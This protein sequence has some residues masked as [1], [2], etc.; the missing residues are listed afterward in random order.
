MNQFRIRVIFVC[1]VLGL[2]GTAVVTR[3]FVVQIIDGKKYAL[4]SK[5]QA[6]QRRI[7]NAKRGCIRDRKGVILASSIPGKLA[8]STQVL[9][10]EGEKGKKAILQRI[11]PAGDVC[12]P[13]LGYIGSDGY[14]LGGAEFA[15]D[16]YLRG[17]DGWEM[18]QK[19][20]R[21]R[22]YKKIGLPQKE[23]LDGSDVYLT[24][25]SDLQK[26]VQ[27][28]LK[29]TV[30]S[31]QARGAMCI[32]MD[33][34]NGKILA[35]ANEPSFNPNVSYMYSLDERRNRCISTV[36]EPGSTFKVVTASVA[37]QEKLFKEQD[38]IDGNNGIFE[39]YNQVIRDVSPQKIITF[40]QAMAVSSNVCFAQ[41]AN[42]FSN[43]LFYRYAR[44]FGFGSKTGIE[45]PGEEEGIL[46][47]V[48]AWSGRTRVT[49]AMGHEV[50][51]TFL[52][53]MLPF[54]CVANGGVLVTPTI[55]EKVVNKNGVVIQKS[56]SK[57]VRKVISGD[58]V[59]KL[60]RM[61]KEVVDN[62][63]GKHAIISGVAVAGKT[64]T[65]R[66][67][68][69]GGY[70]RNKHWSSFIGFLPADDPVLLCGIV[71]DEPVGETGGGTVAAPAFQKI[72]SQVLSHPQ[73]EFAEKILDKPAYVVSKDSSE[74]RSSVSVF[75]KDS[76]L[77]PDSAHPFIP[78]C[79]GKDMR[80]AFNN[81]NL[82]GFEVFAVGSGTVRRQS[83]APGREWKPA[84]VCTLFC[85]YEGALK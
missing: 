50:S 84:Q 56:A 3:L 76:V 44:D 15:F 7:I 78:D 61:L 81:L 33:P 62:G 49:M 6:Q 69:A 10:I 65:S 37:L 75:S 21:R 9:G 85:S 29:Q 11:Y 19:D 35:M 47:P 72:M 57:P 26:I 18:I 22:T 77:V 20:G 55:Y 17:E 13:V 41:I 59:V 30:V 46:H 1:V 27:T 5:S 34:Y 31:L 36:Y 45:L 40:T 52:Q 4:R 25:D 82:K 79:I 83:P 54:A 74:V 60:R 43:Q 53:M 73:L 2:F 67:P 38:L 42:T 58:V 39:I 24:I 64:G 16:S 51:S 14:G 70:S 32:V 48:S 8:M 80:D 28:V 68:D 71:I 66:K 63:T 12:G 23:P